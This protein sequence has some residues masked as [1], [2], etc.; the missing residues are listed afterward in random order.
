MELPKA[1]SPKEVEDKIYKLWEESGFFSPEGLS[2]VASAKEDRFTSRKFVAAIAPPNI[3]GELHI[4]HALENTLEDIVIRMRR[5]QG[6]KT[7]WLPGT[8]HAGIAAQNKVEKQLAKEGLT[9]HKIGREKFLERMWEWREKYGN[10]I[11]D[12][13][14]KLG[15]SVDWTRTQF[16]MNPGYQKAVET[17]FK[18]YQE[19]GWIYRG[20]RVISWC[21][22]CA[23]S[24]SD[25]E[26]NHV[27]EK[28]RLYFIKYGPFVLAT[29][30]PETKLGDTALAVHPSDERYKKYIGQEIEIDSVDNTLPAE[31]PPQ[32][33]K[34]SL[35]VVDDISVD[36]EF[37]T[38]IIKVT[39]AHDLTDYEIS[40]RHNLPLVKIIDERGKMNENAGIRYQGLKVAQAREQIAKDLE[41]L[42]L[43]EK[44]EDYDHNVGH[45]DRCDSVIEPLPSKQWFLKM[46]E[47]AKLAIEALGNGEVVVHSEK[48][49]QDMKNWLTNVRDWNISRQLWWGHKIP[50]DG[51]EDVLDTWFSSALWPFA[52]MGWP[53]KTKDLTEYYP[54][55]FITS[56]RGIRYLW[57]ARMIFSGKFFTGSAPFKDIYIHA[58][59]LTKNGKRMSKSLGTGID[60]L[61]VIE[62]YGADALRFGLAYQTTELQ[63]MRFGEDTIIMGKKFANKFWNIA[64]YVLMKLGDDYE[65]TGT[66]PLGSEI[67]SKM[68]SAAESVTKNIE[69]YK[70][71]EAAHELY[72]FIWHEFADKYIEETKDKDDQ[73]TKNALAYLLL[74][75]LKL[76]HPFMPFITEEVYSKLPIKD[77]GLLI[78]EKW[79]S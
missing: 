16:T 58:T 4:G 32:I 53:E 67:I 8:D 18:K 7:L 36:K 23:T 46:E 6:Y 42:G 48:W 37:G 13:F 39:P 35:K 50:I 73:E 69:K 29:T 34:I 49:G 44:I 2:S 79:P 77:K 5:M 41:T 51:E 38:G 56:D 40:L 19:K 10:I 25:L 45:C 24:I 75:C 31:Q 15:L 30:R 59:V 27:P 55:D 17:A 28:G 66:R 22:R 11:L 3:T 65:I 47:L 60:P 54:T 1:Y 76:L 20:E 70:F 14:K 62:K 72:D 9:R 26:V 52:A 57:Q 61:A 74:T 78:V 68:D 71:G 63:D 12:Q 21:P 64:R 43:I 33:K